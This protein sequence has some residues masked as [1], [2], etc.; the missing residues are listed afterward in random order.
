MTVV[1]RFGLILFGFAVATLVA[2]L[3]HV[4]YAHAQQTAPRASSIDPFETA[5]SYETAQPVRTASGDSDDDLDT[6]PAYVGDPGDDSVSDPQSAEPADGSTTDGTID[7]AEPQPPEDGG[8]P[9]RDTRPP[10]DL[11]PFENP[12]AGFDPLLFQIEDIDPVT[13]DRRPARLARFEPYDPIGI[14]VGSF[15]FFPEIEIGGVWTDNVLSSP[16]ARSDI[17]AEIRSVSR[18][19]SNWSMHALE[20]RGTSLNT[21][22]DEFS[23][24]DDRAWGV[25][26]RGRI[27][28]AR[29]TNLQGIVGHDV[30]QESRSAIDANQVGDRANVTVDRA[31]MALNHRF[32]RLSVQLRGSVSDSTYSD[33]DGFSNADRDTLETTQ[34]VRATWE[35]KPTL[36][37]FAEQELNQR[38]KGGLPADGIS[39]DSEGTRTRV[40]FDFGATGALLRGTIGIGYGH[41]APDASVLSPVDAVLFDANLAWR[42]SEVTSFLLTAQ[43]DI[44]DTTTVES[45]GVISHTVG[46]EAR[47]AFRRYLLGSAGVVYTHY[48]YDAT[49]FKEDQWLSFVGLEYFASPEVVLFTRYQHLDFA[50]NDLDGDYTSDEIRAGVRIRR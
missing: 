17:A 8:D 22:Y 46:I 12:P 7:L 10:E 45:G 48:K 9:T 39:R 41:Q 47:H 21:F 27:D 26:A 44:Y 23:S 5:T 4:P 20:L 15:I 43:S 37:V 18:L 40:G 36:S 13:T 25:E 29:R 24:E 49:P 3:S 28:F 2:A 33:T 16:D 32:N 31:E 50:S 35:F 42:P 34:V 14:R 6:D 30:S 11:A 38:D 19:V 1:W